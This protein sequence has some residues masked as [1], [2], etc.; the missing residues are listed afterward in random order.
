MLAGIAS[1]AHATAMIT[2]WLTNRSRFCVPPTPDLWPPPA[3]AVGDCY[4]GVPSISADDPQYLVPGGSS[5]I[6]WR[7]ENWSPPA[8]LVYLALRRYAHLRVA[9]EARQGLVAQ[10]MELL[11]STWRPHHHVCENYPSS[12]RN[13]SSGGPVGRT[14]PQNECTGNRFYI[15]GGLPALAALTELSSNGSSLLATHGGM[16]RS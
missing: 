16:Y 9:R 7:G 10:Q 2:Q 14:S 5:G 11:L 4:W 3:T 1:D 15:W 13:T 8:Y 6:Y 12:L